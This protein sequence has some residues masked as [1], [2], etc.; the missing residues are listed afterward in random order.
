M[1][2]ICL[3]HFTLKQIAF[4]ISNMNGYLGDLCSLIFHLK[5]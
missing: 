2:Q 4:F 3:L 5:W 1:D